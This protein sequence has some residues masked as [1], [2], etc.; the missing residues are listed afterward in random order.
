MQIS[1]KRS[2]LIIH[3]ASAIAGNKKGLQTWNTIEISWI[4]DYDTQKQAVRQ[5][6]DW[7]ILTV[8][9]LVEVI[10]DMNEIWHCIC[11]FRLIFWR[12]L[13]YGG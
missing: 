5:I 7:K 8:K 11:T 6:G 4:A 10:S 3:D 9:N 13:N 1:R 2:I 12:S